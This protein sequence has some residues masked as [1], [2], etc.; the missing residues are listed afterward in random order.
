MKFSINK[1]EYHCYR[2]EKE[3]AGRELL[4][5]LARIDENFG[6]LKDVDDWAQSGEA[7]AILDDHL[8][9]RITS[10][11]TALVSDPTFRFSDAGLRKARPY[12]RWLGGMFAASPFRNADHILRSFGDVED[13]HN[14]VRLQLVNFPK[15]QLFYMPESEVR[16]DWDVLWKHDKA[17]TASMALTLL[18]SR[19]LGTPAAHAKREQLLAWLPDKLDQVESIGQLPVGVLHSAYM[20]CSYAD[21]PGK[22]DIKKPINTLIRRQLASLGMHDVERKARTPKPGQKP[23]LLVVLEWFSKNHS[24][25]RTHSQTI[26]AMREK[27][28]IVGMGMESRVDE[29][30]REVFHEFI[31]IK[32]DNMWEDVRQVRQVSE[33]REAQALYM[34]SVGMFPVTVVLAC[35]RVAP[36][37]LM[38]LGH[39]ATTHSPVMDYVVVEEDY[40]GDEACFSEKLLKLPHDGM[41]Y[42][43]PAAMLGLDLP[44][45]KHSK[46]D[47]VKI[48]VAGTSIKLNPGFL[49]TCAEIAKAATVPVEFHFLV[50]QAT[51]VIYPM[52]RNHIQRIMGKTAVVHKQQ[53]YDAYMKVIAECDLFLNPFPFGNTN[54]IVD[55]VWAGLVGV[56]KTGREVHEHID[57]GM[58]RRLGFPEW[59]I[60]KTNDEY[61]AAALRLIG[62]AGERLEL[63]R[64]LAGRQAVEKLIFKG[65]PEIL[66]E[67]IEALWQELAGTP[68]RKQR[69]GA[70]QSR[71]SIVKKAAIPATA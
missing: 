65:R 27:F 1:F 40:V 33:A 2:H 31:P 62:D 48:A 60:A 9:T 23:V 44:S 28:H 18:S 59:M 45:R 34:P 20:H 54:G 16:L 61:K 37:Q 70:S 53:N 32:G 8:L 29:V 46:S 11:I 22:H 39:P 58:F 13:A 47:P 10:A 17:A 68:A 15:F 43:A 56:C 38:A 69:A 26:V 55:T 35:T 66:G 42:R 67:R 3:A 36:L 25:Y 19:F 64:T 21:L 30:G 51:G 7:R 49:Q 52:V 50:G 6:I 41:P 71:L 24:I 12:Q 4:K 14:S 5:L 63:S 57:E